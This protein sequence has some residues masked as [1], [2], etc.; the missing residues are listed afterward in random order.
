MANDSVDK[1]S[2]GGVAV[3]RRAVRPP[4]AWR[5]Q[6]FTLRN[7]AEFNGR[8]SRA[9]Y[10]WFCLFQV[11]TSLAFLVPIDAFRDSEAA[12]QWLTA[13]FGLWQLALALPDLAVTV[14]RLHDSGRSGWWF[15]VMMVPAIGPI[16]LLVWLVIRGTCCGNR[17]GADPLA[18]P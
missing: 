16:V 9:E 8:A 6:W 7:Y 5:R 1:S 3:F 2:R 12:T 10:W 11:M 15:L 13:A 18:R 17:F 4:A 14:R